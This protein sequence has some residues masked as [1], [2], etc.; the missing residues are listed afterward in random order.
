MVQYFDGCPHWQQAHVKV[1]EAL[2]LLGGDKHEVVLQR[3]ETAQD[4]ER[5]E[6]HGSPTVLID[7]RDPFARPGAPVGLTCRL[8]ETPEGLAGSPT[9]EQFLDV[10]TR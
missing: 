6:F 4:A 5:L 3:V 10:L 1:Q 8:F 9:V 7:G 2:R